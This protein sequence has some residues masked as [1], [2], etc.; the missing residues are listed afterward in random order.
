MVSPQ[1]KLG[2]QIVDA[3]VF[4]ECAEHDDFR[5]RLQHFLSRWQKQLDETGPSI[6]DELVEMF[7]RG[8]L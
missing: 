5:E 2:F 1:A 4:S 6:D 7:E 3:A 8:E